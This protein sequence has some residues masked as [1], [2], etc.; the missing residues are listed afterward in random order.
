MAY[1][2]VPAESHQQGSRARRVT[3]GTLVLGGRHYL[4][5]GVSDTKDAGERTAD[6]VEDAVLVVS[7]K[8]EAL[9]VGKSERPL[10]ALMPGVRE[11]YGF[12]SRQICVLKPHDVSLPEDG[13]LE[14]P[15]NGLLCG[16]LRSGP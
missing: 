6:P 8:H 4:R 15:S 7:Q 12:H 9:T 14:E 1:V 3:A 11:Q 10:L 5:S 2:R 16:T 13:A